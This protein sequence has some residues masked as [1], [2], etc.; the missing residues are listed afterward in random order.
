M[1]SVDVDEQYRALSAA[2]DP[3]D[4]LLPGLIAGG[5]VLSVMMPN[6]ARIALSYRSPRRGERRRC[7]KCSRGIDFDGGEVYATRRVLRPVQPRPHF[8]AGASASP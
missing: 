8:P 1:G 7:R 4:G 5:A 6:L 2:G 3:L